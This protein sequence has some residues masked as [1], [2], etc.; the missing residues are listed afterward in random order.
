[1]SLAAADRKLSA[2]GTAASQYRD[3]FR[4]VLID[5]QLSELIFGPIPTN[6]G[7]PIAL[8]TISELVNIP[9]R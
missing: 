3:G 8:A 5:P 6:P 7:T 2:Y 1:M 9:K 4:P